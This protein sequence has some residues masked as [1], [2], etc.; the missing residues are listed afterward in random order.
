MSVAKISAARTANFSF[1]A[2]GWAESAMSL[3]TRA[4]A[5]PPCSTSAST[6]ECVMRRRGVSVSGTLATS[7]S[8]ASLFQPTKPSGG[9]FFLIFLSFLGS[10]AAFMAALAFSMS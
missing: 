6:M 8:K 7:F 2:G 9:C 1:S 4:C 3:S 5:S 10:P